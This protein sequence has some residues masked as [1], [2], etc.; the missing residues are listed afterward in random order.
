MAFAKVG[1]ERFAYFDWLVKNGVLGARQGRFHRV[2]GV[3][4]DRLDGTAIERKTPLPGVSTELLYR[5]GPPTYP[6]AKTLLMQVL[7]VKSE[8][9]V[10]ELLD[11]FKSQ[12][13]QRDLVALRARDSQV[14]A[15]SNPDESSVTADE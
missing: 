7:D 5:N 8:R 11:A 1:D 2:L 3:L 10:E 15:A 4:N 12:G 6:E 14:N 13:I 9:P